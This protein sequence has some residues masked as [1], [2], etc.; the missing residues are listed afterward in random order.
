MK[1]LILV[2]VFISLFIGLVAMDNTANAG[3]G[4]QISWNVA[5]GQRNSSGSGFTSWMASSNTTTTLVSTVYFR[6]LPARSSE[7]VLGDVPVAE[8]F[9]ADPSDVYQVTG[10]QLGDKGASNSF[11]GTNWYSGACMP[12]PKF[13]M[14]LNNFQVA[15]TVIN[16]TNKELFLFMDG[17]PDV[18]VA[19]NNGQRVITSTQSGELLLQTSPETDSWLTCANIWWRIPQETSPLPS[20]TSTPRPVEQVSDVRQSNVSDS[21]VTLSF[22]SNTPVTSTVDY[23]VLDSN[24][25]P[26]S[27]SDFRGN[28]AGYT[29][30]VRINGLRASTAYQFRINLN[31]RASYTG[32]LQTLSSGVPPTPKSLLVC[33]SYGGSPTPGVLVRVSR[34][35]INSPLA[36]GW[37]DSSGCSIVDLSSL[38]YHNVSGVSAQGGGGAFLKVWV[39]A[40]PLGEAYA[41]IPSDS[42]GPINLTIRPTLEANWDLVSGWNAIALPV[43]ITLRV[44]DLMSLS[45]GAIQDFYSFNNGQWSGTLI[46][47]TVVLGYDQQLQ[48]GQGYFVRVDHSVRIPLKGWAVQTPISVTLQAS[49]NLVGIPY[50]VGLNVED[51]T[52]KMGRTSSG[53]YYKVPEGARYLLGGYEGHLAGYPVNNWPISPNEGIWLRAIEPIQL[54]PGLIQ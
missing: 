46:S 52:D 3:G 18:S 30:L 37:T 7:L 2:A 19:A 33:T 45:G 40:G 49:W 41:E 38:A 4:R 5:W 23:W 32:T 16:T 22:L 11:A 44:S 35:D 47:G 1:R 20:P 27:A 51:V 54:R 9:K 13:S 6:Y 12:G 26:Q 10:F 25:K 53:T 42:T 50:P 31:G 21:A 34:D 8:G 28:S 48:L 17:I 14:V 39:L 15:I 36:A 24:E 29:H 43:S